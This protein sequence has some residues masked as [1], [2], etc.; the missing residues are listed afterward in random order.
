VAHERQRTPGTAQAAAAAATPSS[1]PPK[2]RVPLDVNSAF[3]IGHML[4]SGAFGTVWQA[5]NRST[6]DKVAIKII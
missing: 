6:G 2:P 4:G 5:Q 3:G 1:S